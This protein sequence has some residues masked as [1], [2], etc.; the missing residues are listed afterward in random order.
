MS[1]ILRTE[2]VSYFSSR[3]RTVY[4]RENLEVIADDDR[5]FVQVVTRVKSR[6]EYGASKRG[7]LVHRPRK[8]T[9]YWDGPPP[10]TPRLVA[11][12]WCGAHCQHPVLLDPVLL[13]GTCVEVCAACEGRAISAGRTASADWFIKLRDHSRPI[14]GVTRCANKRMWWCVGHGTHRPPMPPPPQPI[15]APVTRKSEA[16]IAEHT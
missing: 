4:Q 8:L 7:A 9:I 14:R 1:T 5:R 3:F 2:P 16:M 6:A 13:A 12:W 11:G 15:D 10:R